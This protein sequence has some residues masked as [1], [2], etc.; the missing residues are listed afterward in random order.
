LGGGSGRDAVQRDTAP[1]THTA[2][3]TGEPRIFTHATRTAR[4]ASDHFPVV[5]DIE[6]KA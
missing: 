2:E 4:L 5:A 6:A 3:G 1:F